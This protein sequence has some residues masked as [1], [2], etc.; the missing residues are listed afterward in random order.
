MVKLEWSPKSLQELEA[1]FEY[2]AKDSDEYARIFVKRIIEI[3]KT[4]PTFPMQGRI[5]PEFK[6]DRIRERIFKNYRI[7]YRIQ[8][9]VI[10]IVSIFHNARQLDE[11]D[12]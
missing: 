1:I 11:I 4:I 12:Y 5:V 3:V 8:K 6:D 10:E 9:N 2:I 7:I